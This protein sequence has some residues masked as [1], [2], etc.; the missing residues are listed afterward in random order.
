MLE[1][2]GC[3]ISNAVSDSLGKNT[4]KPVQEIVPGCCVFIRLLEL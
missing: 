4:G 1:R 3:Y 2:C